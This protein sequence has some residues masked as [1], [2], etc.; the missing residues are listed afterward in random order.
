MKKKE[1]H[2]KILLRSFD[3]AIV[4]PLLCAG[5]SGQ[6]HRRK[7]R[8]RTRKLKVEEEE[9]CGM[10]KIMMMRLVLRGVAIFKL[11]LTTQINFPTIKAVGESRE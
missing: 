8:T 2:R 3:Y 6:S 4:H 7:K 9:T 1:A 11:I 5:A 10:N